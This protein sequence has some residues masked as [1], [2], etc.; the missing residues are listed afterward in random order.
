MVL[1]RLLGLVSEERAAQFFLPE[2]ERLY[3]IGD[4]HGRSDLLDQLIARIENDDMSRGSACTSWVFLGDFIDRGVD[5]AGVI[6]RL[7][8]FA[9]SHP[10]AFFLMGNH[11]EVLLRAANGDT[12]A[13]SLFNRIGG[14]ETMLSYGVDPHTYDEATLGMLCTLIATSVPAAH[15]DF[16]G[17]L[18]PFHE[19]G[20]YLFVH[21]GIRPKVA[22]Q[23]QKGS[24]LR[25]IREDFL[26]YN[27]DYGRMVI[28]GHSITS[29]V[30]VQRNRIGIDTGAY[31]SGRLT[32]VGLQ[33]DEHW[34]LST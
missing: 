9:A 22:L 1:K 34:F 14:R 8:A 28:H 33:C 3:A 7:I 11:E 6:D 27:D 18:R 32:A 23:E 30:D 2:G 16:M 13:A 31:V 5:S 24:D 12:R 19:S 10:R 29:A 21:A 17:D 26:N 15:I 20:D 25:W 4:I